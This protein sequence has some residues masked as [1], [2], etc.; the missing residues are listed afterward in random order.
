MVGRMGVERDDGDVVVADGN[1][2]KCLP[3]YLS[4]A[5]HWRASDSASLSKEAIGA[6]TVV[7]V[8]LPSID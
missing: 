3:I 7:I 5:L 2:G 6:V 4:L 1:G 8:D